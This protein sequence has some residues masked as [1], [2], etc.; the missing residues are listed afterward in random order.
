GDGVAHGLVLGAPV[1]PQGGPDVLDGHAPAFLAAG[2]VDD[3]FR[4]AGPVEHHRLGLGGGGEAFD[5]EAFDG[6]VT[7]D[8]HEDVAVGPLVGQRRHIPYPG[9]GVVG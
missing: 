8:P 3:G 5:G 7:H 2:E 1:R 9:W 4:R 6:D